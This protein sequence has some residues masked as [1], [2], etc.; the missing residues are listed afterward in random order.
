MTKIPKDVLKKIRVAKKKNSETL[1]LSSSKLTTLPD[2]ICELKN[3][4]T[5]DLSQNR[6]TTIPDS[7][8]ALKVLKGLNLSH[9]QLMTLPDSIGELKYL[10]WLYLYI[11]QLTALPDSIGELKNLSRFS[12]H[13]N[14]LTLIPDCIGGLK[15][16]T[17]LFLNDNQLISLP[18]SIGTLWNLRELNLSSNKLTSLPDSIRKLKNLKEFLLNGNPLKTPPLEV[19]D[20]GIDAIRDYF[21][22]IEDEGK[23]RLYEAKLLIV[24]E[25]GAGKTTLARKIKN[26][27]SELP[28]DDD[29]TRGI[30]VIHWDFPMETGQ[31]F[32]VNIWDFGGQEIYKATHQ[33][34]LTERSLYALVAD[35]RKEDTD[36]YYWL[37]VVELLSNGSP[38]LIIKNEKQD[39]KR[40]INERQ[41]R[42]QFANLKESLATNLATNRGLP[43]VLEKIKHYITSLPLV[44]AELPKT[45]VNVRRALESRPDNY[46]KLDEYLDICETNG[47]TRPGDKLQLSGYLH[48]LGVCLHFQKDP[49]LKNIVILKTDWGTDAVYKVLDDKGV[50]AAHGMFSRAYVAKIW[51]DP[52]YAGMQDEL[53][54]L[55][56]NF[57]LCYRIPGIA[58]AYIAP[59]L[60]SGDQPE[61]D[62]DE[63]DNLILRYTYEFMP[64]GI[65][66]QLIVAMHKNIADQNCAWKSGVIFEKDGTKA[67]IIEHYDRREMKIRITGKHRKELMT[68][69]TWELE[70]IHA[71][72]NRL[73][74][75]KLIPCNCSECKDSQEPHFYRFESL[76]KRVQDRKYQVECDVSYEEVDVLRLID[77]VIDQGVLKR[78]RDKSGVSIVVQGDVHGMDIQKYEREVKIMK[79]RVIEIGNGAHV[80]APIV[81]ADSIQN[82]F[83][84]LAESDVSPEIKALLN[85]LLKAVNEVNKAVPPEEAKSAETMARD[86]ETLIKEATSP[87]PRRKWHK[88]SLDDI[89]KAAKDIGEIANPVLDIVGKLLPLLL[90]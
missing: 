2:A 81:I 15:D 84:T 35:A 9:N 73:R 29:T 56:I 12:V 21:R 55:M 90:S 16:L 68:V 8:C 53:L 13:H 41:L 85:D 32:R 59:Q 60:L 58:D 24:G 45:W 37:N 87:E 66:T 51:N 39:R 49:V 19:C 48:D 61:Y 43:D 82:S 14:Q 72:Y 71:S 75:K 33:F 3:L 10:E 23:D 76:R 26:P 40:G 54:Q 17:G 38:L 27:D 69:V 79:E 28:S 47:I 22:Q 46:I 70:R 25:G 64:K 65:I 67:E 44:G 78:E 4:E 36:F 6:L 18:D 74:Y 20:K 50:I 63:E 88:I 31:S 80:S 62:W 34:F 89:K 83:N 52:K 7:I 42:G 30:D 57:G 1:D 11:N 77:D 86:T 5:L